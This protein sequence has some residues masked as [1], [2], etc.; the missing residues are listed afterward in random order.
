MMP[1]GRVRAPSHRGRRSAGGQAGFSLIEVLAAALIAAVVAG[2]TMMAFVTAARI[3]RERGSAGFVEASTYAQQTAERFRN[4]IACDSAW[5]TPGTCA[6]SASL[7]T[8]WT[9]DPLPAAG[10]GQSILASPSKRC[11]RATQLANCGPGAATTP[12]FTMEVYVC[13]NG[14]T[15][16]PCP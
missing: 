6:P 14:D 9:N 12:C 11:Y 4:M 5:F 15:S 2:G 3:T 10:S 7:P 13:W 16:C 1:G 8:D